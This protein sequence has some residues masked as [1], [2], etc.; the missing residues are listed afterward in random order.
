[1]PKTCIVIAFME[2]LLARL[3]LFEKIFKIYL[4]EVINIVSTK[5]RMVVLLK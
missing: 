5:K 1:M 3:Y 2:I 4:N